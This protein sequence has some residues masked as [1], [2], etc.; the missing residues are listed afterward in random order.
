MGDA[1]ITLRHI[2]RRCPGDLIDAV[3]QRTVAELRARG[4]VFWLVFAPLARDATLAAMREVLAEIHARAA[5][6][7]E[8]VDLITAFL[9]IASVDPWEHNLRKE[10]TRMLTREMEMEMIRSLPG[11]EKIAVEAFREEL[12]SKSGQA[13]GCDARG[14]G[15]CDARGQ[16]EGASGAARAP[17]CAAGRAPADGR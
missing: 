13:G 12:A 1:D 4:S 5:N 14:H 3:Y 6:Y 10:L 11:I 2:A 8:R 9:E 15:G 17:L 16:A 7:E